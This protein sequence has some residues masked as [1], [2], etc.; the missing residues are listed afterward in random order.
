MKWSKFN[1]VENERV[2]EFCD[3]IGNVERFLF[4]STFSQP[5]EHTKTTA[6]GCSVGEGLMSGVFMFIDYYQFSFQ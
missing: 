3:Y 2:D 5:I 4:I 1:E 6:E